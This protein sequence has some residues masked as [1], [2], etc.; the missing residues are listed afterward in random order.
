MIIRLLESFIMKIKDSDVKNNDIKFKSLVDQLSSFSV[1]KRKKALLS[2]SRNWGTQAIELIANQ[3]LN[4]SNSFI[5]ELSIIILSKYHTERIVNYFLKVLKNNQEKTKVRGRAVW[6]LGKMNLKKAKKY[7]IKALDDPETEVVYWAIWGI[8]Q[9]HFKKKPTKKLTQI[10]LKSQKMQIRK[11]AA[12]AMGVIGDETFTKPLLTVLKKKLH[13][14]TQLNVLFAFRRIK[15][16]QTMV[17]IRELLTKESK[18]FIRREAV[19]ALGTIIQQENSRTS[20]KKEK[21]FTKES[22]RVIDVLLHLLS[23]D[24]RYF[25]RRVC[26]E[27]LGKIKDHKVILKLIKTLPTER[28]PFVRAEIIRSLGKMGDKRAIPVLQKATKSR[29][30]VIAQAAGEALTNIN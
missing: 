29:Y 15:A 2:L 28:N 19:L 20:K 10:L 17:V 30:K 21:K 13:H 25:V 6:A 7:T 14:K 24:D 16:K 18:M 8:T 5:R 26:A 4:D 9:P 11:Q 22:T 12:W 23:N 3:M 1:K 27:V